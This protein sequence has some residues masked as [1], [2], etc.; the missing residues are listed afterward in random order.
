MINGSPHPLAGQQ[1]PPNWRVLAEE[2]AKTAESDYLAR[3]ENAWRPSKS[4]DAPAVQ[5]CRLSQP[6]PQWPELFGER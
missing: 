2:R 5:S 3:M 1:L 6:S 4:K